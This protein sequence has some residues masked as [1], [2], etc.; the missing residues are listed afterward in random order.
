M[1]FGKEIKLNVTIRMHYSQ[2]EKDMPPKF[3]LQP[4]F[5][6]L[7]PIFLV[8]LKHFFKIGRINSLPTMKYGQNN[9]KMYVMS[10]SSKFYGHMFISLK[11]FS[12]LQKKRN[13]RNEKEVN[14][15]KN[16]VMT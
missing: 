13:R 6:F 1:F 4:K 7:I 2:A 11:V 15:K 14:K 10:F 9:V 8:L 16:K 12:A 3:T 5:F